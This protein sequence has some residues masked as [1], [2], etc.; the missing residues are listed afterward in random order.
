MQSRTTAAARI[1]F[2]PPVSRIARDLHRAGRAD[3]VWNEATG[4]LMRPASGRRIC[5]V[6][7]GKVEALGVLRTIRSVLKNGAST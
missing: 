6:A 3:P 5:A 4:Y 1:R 2:R 7:C